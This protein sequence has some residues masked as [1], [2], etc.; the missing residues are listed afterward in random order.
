LH[1]FCVY[2]E[3]SNGIFSGDT[4]GLCY[5][6]FDSPEGKFIFATTTPVQFDPDTLI[7]SIDRLMKLSPDYFY[8]TH[9]GRI[10][11]TQDIAHQLKQTVTDFADIARQEK[12]ATHRVEAIEKRLLDYLLDKLNK[13][14]CQYDKEMSKQWLNNDANLNAQGL[15][16]WLKRLEKQS[17]S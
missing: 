1:H 6:Q 12:E 13:M 5:P 3:T 4:F 7:A 9:F 14:R 17:Q 2:D 15:D 11:A 8:L 16:V 10:E